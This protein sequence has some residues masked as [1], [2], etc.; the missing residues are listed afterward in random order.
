MLIFFKNMIKATVA[1]A[2]L[3]GAMFLAFGGALTVFGT[4]GSS[5][6]A[7]L[8]LIFFLVIAGTFAITLSQ[9]NE[10][11]RRAEK[12]FNAFWSW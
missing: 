12:E 5:N 4:T 10:F 8:W 1:L 9:D 3:L 6:L 11:S 2:L 7:A